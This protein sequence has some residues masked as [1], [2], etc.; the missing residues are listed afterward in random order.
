MLRTGNW[1][2]QVWYP[3]L[4]FREE[5]IETFTIATEQGKTYLCKRGGPCQADVGV[6]KVDVKVAITQLLVGLTTKSKLWLPQTRIL[7]KL[8]KI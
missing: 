3:L 7:I 2:T 5:G 1:F 4:R 6:D 8:S